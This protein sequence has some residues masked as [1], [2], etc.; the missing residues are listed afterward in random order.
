MLVIPVVVVVFTTAVIYS[1]LTV[2]LETQLQF[3][4]KLIISLFLY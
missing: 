2:S 1:V 4:R 3:T